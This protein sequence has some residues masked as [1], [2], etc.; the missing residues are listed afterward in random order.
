[1]EQKLFRKVEAVGILAVD[2][3]KAGIG[4]VDVGTDLIAEL[5]LRRSGP[6]MPD[7]VRRCGACHHGHEGDGAG[8]ATLDIERRHAEAIKPDPGKVCPRAPNNSVIRE[9]GGGIK[10]AGCPSP[11]PV[12]T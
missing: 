11:F 3:R 12:F 1:M 7:H 9:C 5:P 2:R 8:V 6:E 10:W 4:E